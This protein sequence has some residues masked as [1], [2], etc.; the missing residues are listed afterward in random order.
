MLH[1]LK[2]AK[3]SRTKSRRVGRGPGSGIGKTSGRG[4]GGQRSRSGG[5]VKAG[6]EGGQ[7]PPSKKAAEARI[8]QHLPH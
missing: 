2:P 3:G 8:H 4:H 6:F 1:N 5:G 7:M